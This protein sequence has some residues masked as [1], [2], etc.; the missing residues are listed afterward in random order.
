MCQLPGWFGDVARN[1]GYQRRKRQ[2][3]RVDMAH[4]PFSGRPLRIS[5]LLLSNSDSSLDL[6]TT[7]G[8]R[9]GSD[10]PHWDCFGI[11]PLLSVADVH[12]VNLTHAWLRI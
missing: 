1:T 11:P 4:N 5:F 2:Q 6:L 12:F 9:G 8:F 7:Q 3:R 10:F